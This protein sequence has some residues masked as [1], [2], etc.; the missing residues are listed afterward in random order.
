MS[1]VTDHATLWLVEIDETFRRNLRAAREA[2]GLNPDQLAKLAGL[3][4]RAVRD[5]EEHRSLSPK[6]STAFALAE[7][8]GMDPGELLGLGRRPRLK[9][10]VVAFLEQYDEADQARFLAALEAFRGLPT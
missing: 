9:A 8:L 4:R 1:R 2:R 3:N 7:A 10:E 5:I 6:L